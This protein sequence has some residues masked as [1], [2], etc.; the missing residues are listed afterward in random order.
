MAE[1]NALLRITGREVLWQSAWASAKD[2]GPQVMR[3]FESIECRSVGASIKLEL[4]DQ[5]Y[6]C[7]RRRDSPL[8][9]ITFFVFASVFSNALFL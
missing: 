4:S 2:H 7:P 8:F 1:F 6:D 5:I 9:Y 3:R